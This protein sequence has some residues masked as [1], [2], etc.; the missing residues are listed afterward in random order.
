MSPQRRDK[1]EEH[2]KLVKDEVR[3]IFFSIF[4]HISPSQI[5]EGQRPEDS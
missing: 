3:H 2:G 1:G 5:N 4:K